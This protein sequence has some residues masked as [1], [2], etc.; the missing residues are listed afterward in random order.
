MITVGTRVKYITSDAPERIKEGYYPPIGTL[1]T[2]IYANGLNL[3]VKWDK[4]T[5]GDGK[6]WC[7]TSD[8]EVV[9][10]VSCLKSGDV[11]K[12]ANGEVG[13]VIRDLDAIIYSKGSMSISHILMNLNHMT[14]SAWDIIAVRRP[15]T[16]LGCNFDAFEH[17]LCELIYERKQVE[18]MTLAEVCKLLGKEIKII[19]GR[20]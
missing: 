3:E 17:N 12:H 8:V 14:N 2:V 19:S 16:Y 18:E 11:V 4:G 20:N 1:G 5:K 13:I 15:R 7:Y 6:W 10:D 9:F